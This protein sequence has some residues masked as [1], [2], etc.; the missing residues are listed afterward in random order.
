L[1]DAISGALR[2]NYGRAVVDMLHHGLFAIDVFAGIHGR[3]RDFA[4]PVI[5]GA[6]DDGVDIFAV[7][8]LLVMPGGEDLRAINLLHVGEAAVVAIAGGDDFGEAGGGG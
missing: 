8:D 6:D 5:G 1:H 2:L 7:E 4:V 3:N